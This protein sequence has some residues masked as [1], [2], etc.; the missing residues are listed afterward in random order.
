MSNYNFN[1][2]SA[3]FRKSVLHRIRFGNTIRLKAEL[4]SAAAAAAAAAAMTPSRTNDT[5][6][7]DRRSSRTGTDDSNQPISSYQHYQQTI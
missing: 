2:G 3:L 6:S 5:Q 4:D 1:D 7:N